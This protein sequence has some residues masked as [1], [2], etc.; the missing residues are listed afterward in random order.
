[1][2]DSDDRGTVTVPKATHRQLVEVVVERSRSDIQIEIAS[3]RREGKITGAI[4][5]VGTANGALIFSYLF[6]PPP[7]LPAMGLQLGFVTLL[8][9]LPTLFF[10]IR[11]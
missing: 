2:G 4:A 9:L 1:M 11:R 7:S 5:T 10:T 8:S 3:Q 6:V